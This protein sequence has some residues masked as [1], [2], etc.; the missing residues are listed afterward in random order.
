M[1]KI[2]YTAVLF[3]PSVLPANHE[4][5]MCTNYENNLASTLCRNYSSDDKQ[6]RALHKALN[7]Y[8]QCELIPQYNCRLVRRAILALPCES[9]CESDTPQG[10]C[11]NYRCADKSGEC[12]SGW[13]SYRETN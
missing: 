11:Y 13:S 8:K 1:K 5:R 3:L 7:Y 10:P 6:K 2:L 4:Y 12:P 9:F